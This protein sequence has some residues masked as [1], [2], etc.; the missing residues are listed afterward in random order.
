M[1]SL[2]F[3]GLALGLGGG[4]SPGP[5]LALT[6]SQALRYG[7]R[8]GIKVAAAPIMTDLP[9]ILVAVFALSRLSALGPVLGVVSLS[10]A[11]FLFYLG[12]ESMTFRGT[13]FA[14][15]P[16][17]PRS[18]RK[19]VIANFLNPS[20]YLFWFTIGG[21]I[22]VEAWNGPPLGPALFVFTMY[23]SLVGSKVVIAL[24]VGASKM[25][26]RSRGY[27]YLLR[28]MGLV[29]WGFALKFLADGLGYFGAL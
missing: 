11:L 1:V 27:I 13:E 10:G 2:I 20:P 7:P 8:E 25:S 4:L 5:L 12:W 15:S 19:G 22:L 6:I 18:L 21:P 23:L 9:I 28:L 26:L 14:D 3:S 17:A 16:R 29:L 24:L